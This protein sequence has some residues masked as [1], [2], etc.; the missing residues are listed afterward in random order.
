MDRADAGVDRGHGPEG[1][2]PSGSRRAPAC[3]WCREPNCREACPTSDVAGGLRRRWATRCW[4]RRAPAAAARACEWS[5]RRRTSSDALA[6]ARREAR[7]S[8]GDD[9]VF[10]ERYLAGARHVE[11]QVFG[12][13]QGNVVHLFERECSIQ[14]R[15]QK[16]IEEA[17]SPG[18]TD[19]VRAR[20]HAAAVS[21]APIDRLRRRGNRR[22][23]GL[24]RGRR[25]GVLLPGDEHP[26]AGRAPGHRGD[27][28]PRPR[29]LADRGGAGRATPA[30]RSTRS[31][32]AGTRS[33]RGCTPRTPRTTTCRRPASIRRFR[34]GCIRVR[35]AACCA[36]TRA[37]RRQ[38]HHAALRP[39]ARQG[40]RPCA[41][42]RRRGGDPGRRARPHDAARPRHEPGLARRDPALGRLPRRSHDHVLPRRPSRE[43]STG[44]RLRRGRGASCDRRVVRPR[45]LD[46][47]DPLVPLGWSNVPAFPSS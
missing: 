23:H 27:H 38:R 16:V 18:V 44:H 29:R 15:H 11:V 35:P 9:T 6:S 46:D 36:S 25:A 21:L 7:S 5:R 43:V 12:D 17:P 14:R 1:A 45:A 33:R 26:P 28:R 24:R 10:V 40:H 4:S 37:C 41:H 22:V 20:L 47:P 8:F 34:S 3:R 2:R 42:A 13:V 39:D 31:W 19:E 30:R 32:L